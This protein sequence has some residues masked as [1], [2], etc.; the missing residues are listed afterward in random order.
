MGVTGIT[1]NKLFKVRTY[2]NEQP[3]KIGFNGVTSI[4]NQQTNG[5]TVI[6]YEIDGIKYTTY[7]TPG[8]LDIFNT[9]DDVITKISV[10]LVDNYKFSNIISNTE[11]RTLI[12]SSLDVSNPTKIVKPS[13]NSDKFFL[14]KS[15]KFINTPVKQLLSRPKNNSNS[16]FEYGDTLFE[17]KEFSYKQYVD[18]KITKK[19]DYVGLIDEPAIN[20]QIFIERD[21]FA[22]MERQQRISEINSLFDLEN[23]KNGY[24][25]NIKTI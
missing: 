2:D 10:S 23:Y 13:K 16:I 6:K 21:A 1:D 12:Q 5:Y 14:K 22:I 9:G 18:K 15:L 24:Y 20:P 4:N 25:K 11:K 17:T 7:V 19:E 3:Y 8:S